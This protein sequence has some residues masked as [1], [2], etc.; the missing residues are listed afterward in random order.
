[1][2]TSAAIRQQSLLSNGS[3]AIALR[4]P[5][6]GGSMGIPIQ[7]TGLAVDRRECVRCC[8]VIQAID[9]IWRAVLPARARQLA[10]SLTAYEEVREKEG[11]WSQDAEFYLSLPWRDTTGR[12]ADQWR[13][14][15]RSFDFVRK[16]VLP[17]CMKRL[18]KR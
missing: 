15:A 2:S 6:C 16:H 18:G 17:E 9:G 4:C 10:P 13:I 5:R 3:A 1:M 7:A 12:F 11:R 14:R 8:T